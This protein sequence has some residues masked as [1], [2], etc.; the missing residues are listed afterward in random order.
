VRERIW[1]FLGG[2]ARENKATAIGI[3]GTADHIH[4]L[5]MAPAAM[6]LSKMVQLFKGGSSK[7]I[8]ETL[9]QMRDFAWQDGY[10]AFT[11]SKSQIPEVVRYIQGQQEHHRAKTFQE[12]YLGFLEKHGI[13]YDP[14]YVWG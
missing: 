7:W 12:E 10:G 14:R 5:I 1:A 13:E 3:G 6:A 8:H 11:V 9:P 4:L 2:I